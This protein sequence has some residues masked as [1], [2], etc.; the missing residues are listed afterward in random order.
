MTW[1]TQWCDHLPRARHPECKIKT[2]LILNLILFSIN[3]ARGGDRIPVEL[4]QILKDD[5]VPVL[6]SVCQWT[7]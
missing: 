2:A 4:F 6:H 1:I 5:A 3:K 7:V